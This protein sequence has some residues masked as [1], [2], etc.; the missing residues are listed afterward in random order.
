M[1]I[2]YVVILPQGFGGFDRQFEGFKR[3]HDVAVVSRHVKRRVQAMSLFGFSEN[4]A[5]AG[6]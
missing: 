2:D 6:Y 1:A 5:Q 3:L 4:F